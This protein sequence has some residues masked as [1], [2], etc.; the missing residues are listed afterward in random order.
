MGYSQVTGMSST[1]FPLKGL[2]CGCSGGGAPSMSGLGQATIAPETR[3]KYA[4]L[5][6]GALVVVQAAW[7]INRYPE[8]VGLRR[9]RRRR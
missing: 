7:W 5:G 6:L 1:R 3:W 9:N 2:G 8:A 4:A